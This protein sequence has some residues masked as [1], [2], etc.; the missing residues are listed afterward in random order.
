M[1]KLLTP[2]KDAFAKQLSASGK[3]NE[4]IL[5]IIKLQEEG[6][7]TSSDKKTKSL[8][9][10]VKEVSEDEKSIKVRNH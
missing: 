10:S 6:S 8:D 7:E 3:A 4:A 9:V 2:I 1:S 5:R